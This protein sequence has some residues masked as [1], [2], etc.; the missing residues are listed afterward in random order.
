V[1][2]F[3]GR[4]VASLAARIGDSSLAVY[5]ALLEYRDDY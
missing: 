4:D 2:S 5:G 1:G 3:E